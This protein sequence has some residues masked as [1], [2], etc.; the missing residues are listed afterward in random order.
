[1]TAGDLQDVLV[2]VTAREP[3]RALSE[4]RKSGDEECGAYE[5]W[6]LIRRVI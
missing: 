1:M 4:M 2:P 6:V 3:D 5:G